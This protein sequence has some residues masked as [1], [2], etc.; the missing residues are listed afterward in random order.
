MSKWLLGEKCMLSVKQLQCLSRTVHLK[1]I[2][3]TISVKVSSDLLMSHFKMVSQV[4]SVIF[5]TLKDTPSLAQPL[6][7]F[8]NGTFCVPIESPSSSPFKFYCQSFI[9]FLCLFNASVHIDQSLYKIVS[10]YFI[11]IQQPHTVLLT[12]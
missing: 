11:G 2:Y 1:T 6:H 12:M 3:S 4:P 10:Y 7:S 9:H 8:I 5:S